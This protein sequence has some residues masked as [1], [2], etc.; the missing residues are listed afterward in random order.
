MRQPGLKIKRARGFLL[1]VAVFV[2]VVVALAVVALGNM[3]SADIRASSEH[4]QSEQAY[5]A[6][7]SG[8]EYAKSLFL[9]GTACGAGLNTT[10]AVGN[11]T[12]TISNA[13][14]YAPAPTNTAA[15]G[16]NATATTIPVVS[17]LNYAPYGRIVIDSEEMYYSAISGNSFIN[18]VRGYGNTIA[19]THGTVT[20]V[21]VVQSLCNVQSVGTTGAATRNLTANMPLQFYQ[22]GV[23]TKKSTAGTGT[24]AYT[25]IGFKPSVVIFYWTEQTATGTTANNTG[26]SSGLGFAAATGTTITNYAAVTGMEDNTGSSSNGRRR[27]AGNAVIFQTVTAAPTLLAQANLQSMDADGFTLNW[28]TNGNATAYRINYI[29]LGGDT[30]GYVGNFNMNNAAGNQQITGTGF[31]PDFMMF[32]HG[33][34]GAL[35]ANLTDAEL[36]IGFAQSASARGAMVYAGQTGINVNI[37][38]RWQQLTDKVILFLNHA[39]TPPTARGQADFVSMDSNGFT[40]N[41]TTA[42]GGAGWNV[43][44]LALRGARVN[45]GRFNEPGA[46]G[47]QT[48]VTSLTFRPKGVFLASRSLATGATLAAGRTAIGAGGGAPIV[49]G[50]IWFQEQNGVNTSNA[51]SYN[52]A[53]NIITMGANNAITNVARASLQSL[54]LGGFTLNWGARNATREILYWVVGPRNYADVNEVFP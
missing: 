40:I 49:D 39:A 18:I 7:A 27:S 53:T 47:V 52:D 13:T 45:A 51:N 2:L 24:V 30:Q 31:Q 20:A 10:A 21:P 1:I 23:I 16:V 50:N 19:A 46:T 33:A 9:T 36:G 8:I 48:P 28:T 43:G 29:A 14:Q 32:I 26:V 6:A 17:T 54:D 42:S 41:V 25:G 44:Y 11:G 38:P 37:R 15:G 12:F 4:A 3:T 5:F 34:D 35:D 22:T